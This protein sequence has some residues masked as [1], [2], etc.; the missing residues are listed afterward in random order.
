MDQPTDPD[1]AGEDA[2]SGVESTTPERGSDAPTVASDRAAPEVSALADRIPGYR[3]VGMLGEGGM[4][5]VLEAEQD[6]PRRRVALKMIRGGAFAGSR[7]VE[8]FRREVATLAR[9]R[10]PHIAAIH[11]A[12]TS[13]DGQPFLA[14]ELVAGRTLSGYLGARERPLDRA[15]VRFRLRLIRKICAAVHHAHQRGVIHRDLKPGNILVDAEVADAHGIPEIKILDFGLARLT[16]EDGAGSMAT[17]AGAIQG[18]LAYMSPEQARGNPHEIDTRTDV[19][20][21]GVILYE[22]LSGVRPRDLGTAS[23]LDAVR[24]VSEAP[25]RPLAQ[26]WPEGAVRLDDD[27]DTIVRTALAPE[28]DRRY[29]GADALAQD[30]DRYLA[31]QPIH[32]RPPSTLYQVRLFARRNRVLVGGIAA[33]A[34][35]LIA[36]IVVSSLLAVSEARQRREVERARDEIE[37]VVS[38]QERMLR[39]LDPEQTGLRL[40]AA[41]DRQLPGDRE[42][43]EP[44]ELVRRLRGALSPTDLAREVLDG[45][46]LAPSTEAVAREF[47]EQPG[48]EA[49]MHHTL[50]GTYE[51]LGL[52]PSAEREFGRAAEIRER[53]FGARAPATLDSLARAARV[54]T[55]RD[56]GDDVAGRLDALIAVQRDVLGPDH[57]STLASRHDRAI[58]DYHAGRLGAAREAL[59]KL[60]AD[61]RR[62]LGPDDPDTLTTAGVLA[63]VHHQEGDFETARGM[64]ADVLAARRRVLGADDEVTVST[65]TNLAA[66]LTRLDRADE[67]ERLLREAWER[68]R[69]TKGE[70]YSRTLRAINNLSALYARM[71]RHREAYE[72]AARSFEIRRRVLGPSHPETLSSMN[73]AAVGLTALGRYDEAAALLDDL[74]ALVELDRPGS[75]EHAVYVHT[76]AELEIAR[77][78]WAEARRRLDFAIGAY[79][80]LGDPNLGFALVQAAEVEARSGRIEAALDRL[81]QAVAA[82]GGRWIDPGG[83][84]W[85]RLRSTARFAAIARAL[86]APPAG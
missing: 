16:D 25:I 45:T 21:L 77:G 57:R 3:V 68:L 79:R 51:E 66:V 40:F 7:A 17:Q 72:L 28:A 81:D 26:V 71:G 32:A 27:L 38:F 18:T 49:R 75:R 41:I 60:L 74:V 9:L 24:I 6:N 4:G 69:E 54:A 78:R 31:D 30:L 52:F 70:E 53:L 76:F 73:N 43:G 61:Q 33:T 34:I 55:M 63:A 44:H 46:I 59:E 14:M 13:A 42:A 86:A 84:R 50:G 80:R 37:R 47:A 35:V 67:A 39:E 23:F 11:D 65:M 64:Y 10:H 15:E 5:V 56:A 8:R 1:D 82:G 19:Y 62:A 29:S 36:G 22:A 48:L 83:D 20:A 85:D 2:G 58:V 12:G